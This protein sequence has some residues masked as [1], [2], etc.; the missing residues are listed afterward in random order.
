LY[1]WVVFTA[2]AAAALDNA[3]RDIKEENMTIDCDRVVSIDD[4]AMIVDEECNGQMN[5]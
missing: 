1:D 4:A 5:T 2:A 3:S